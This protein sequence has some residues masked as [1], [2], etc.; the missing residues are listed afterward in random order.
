M[1]ELAKIPRIRIAASDDMI[2]IG[3]QRPSFKLP[4]ELL[5]EGKQEALEQVALLRRIEQVPFVKRAGGDEIH[6]VVGQTMN[7]RVWPVL[8]R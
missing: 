3:E 1:Q 2:V 4:A 6:S 8:G 5:G 7:R